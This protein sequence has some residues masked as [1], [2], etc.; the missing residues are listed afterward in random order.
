MVSFARFSC[1]GLLLASLAMPAMAQNAAGSAPQWV[2]DE[3]GYYCALA[4]KVVGAPGATLVLRTLPGTWTYDI[5]LVGERWPAKIVRARKQI[6]FALFPGAASESRPPEAALLDRDRMITLR[7]LGGKLIDDFPHSTAL[8]VRADGK[9]VVR[10]ALPSNPADASQALA[11]CVAS[12]LIEAGADPA[13]F[14]P[15]ARAPSPIGDQNKWL[16]LPPILSMGDGEGLHA[17]VMLDLDPGGKPT[18]CIVL[19]ISGRLDRERLCQNLLQRARYE[20]ARDPKGKAL[21]SIAV[22][23]LDEMIRVT[24]TVETFGG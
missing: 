9:P 8:E 11:K 6:A 23:D 1:A 24:V 7:G 19:E 5:M 12:K 2:V 20:P 22:Y 13:G 4:T 14:E 21:R 15:G 18:D 17:A 10:Y 3:S 16:D